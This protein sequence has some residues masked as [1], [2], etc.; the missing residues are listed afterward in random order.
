M[1]TPLVSPQWLQEHH[2]QVIVLDATWF[3]PNSPQTGLDHWKQAHIPQ[4]RFFDFDEIADHNQ[5]LPHML[6]SSVEF[7]QA[8]GKLGIKNNDTLVIYDAHGIFS[9]PR[10][11]WMFTAMGHKNTFVLNGGLPAWIA[12]GYKTES[13]VNAEE[14]SPQTYHAQLNHSLVKSAK[15]VQTLLPNPTYKV[16]DARAADRF[17]GKT[18]E[19]RDDLRSGHMPNAKN[20]PF[21]QLLINGHYRDAEDLKAAF[22]NIS[23]QNDTEWVFT[24]GS[25]VTACILALGATVAGI[26]NIAVYDGSWSEWGK[27]IQY[28]VVQCP[29]LG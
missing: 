13:G 6:P 3:M 28:P 29:E 1:T 27:E 20:L 5:N 2:N 16:V 15:A 4:A 17:Y 24:C 18:P 10:V 22:D 25:G 12:A 9:A 26:K 14:V 21:N 7:S 19:P 23:R 8:V 11:W